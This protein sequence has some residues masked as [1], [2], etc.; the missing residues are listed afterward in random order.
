MKKKRKKT[1]IWILVIVFL[2]IVSIWVTVA[3][4]RSE[5]IKVAIEQAGYKDI[6][7]VVSANGKVYPETE[8]KVSSDVSGEIVDLPVIE[9]D[10][11]RKGQ[12]LVKIYAD[13]YGSMR[14]KANAALSQAQAQQANSAA[15]LAAY[16]AKLDQTKLAYD[17]NK[18]LFAQKV[19]SRS[20][21]ET[22][23]GTYRSALADY[24]AAVESVNSNRFAV[25]SARAGLTEANTNL[26]RTTI[27]APMN[28]IVSLLPMKKGE[29]V[30]GTAQMTGT[31]IMRIA[32]LNTMEVQVDVGENDIPRVKYN[33]TAIIEVDA[34]NSRK[35][36]G[37]VTQIASSSKNA[38]T[39]TS[40]TASSAD[41]VTN[42]VVHIR[43]L[44]ESYKD[45]ITG[46]KP[47]P[48]RPG[49]SASVDIQ[50]Q[51]KNNVLSVPI[52]A[53][54]KE[55]GENAKDNNEV[56]FMLQ[57]DKTVKQVRVTTGVQDNDYIEILSGIKKGEAVVT[58]P[59]AAVSKDLAND[60]KVKV[61]AKK[62]LFEGTANQ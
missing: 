35:F 13:V 42:Y 53:V 21:F 49:M 43:I 51:R 46:K 2:I 37:I 16:K 12:V 19:V 62:D 28:G 47:Y 52:N 17:R 14:D 32:D 9:G 33:D 4:K 25:A 59:Y 6:I 60:K 56:V 11:V 26:N 10:S 27:V 61:V 54:T 40:T 8:V 39:S 23:E 24:N 58:A 1:L 31:E 20:E 57:P 22:A 18:E 29:R 44:Q 3:S 55:R 45:L 50:T 38:A 36:K 48:F 7:E 30:V 41:Q 5:G 15:S 34:Y